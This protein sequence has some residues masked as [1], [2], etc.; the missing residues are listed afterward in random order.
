MDRCCRYHRS[1]DPRFL[2]L[3][4]VLAMMATAILLA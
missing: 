4:V 2:I 3:S 1:P